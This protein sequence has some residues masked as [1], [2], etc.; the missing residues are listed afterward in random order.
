MKKK[1]LLILSSLILAGGQLYAAIST[2][3]K[4]NNK[5]KYKI[6][7]AIEW[8]TA[9]K[10]VDI[11]PNLSQ[12]LPSKKG[13]FRHI[14]WNVYDNKG[15]E[16]GSYRTLNPKTADENKLD[17]KDK[18][19]YEKNKLNFK[20]DI[21]ERYEYPHEITIKGNG[22]TYDIREESGLTTKS[23][24]TNVK[25]FNFIQEGQKT[26]AVKVEVKPEVKTT[27]TEKKQ[28][29][30][31]KK[32][33]ELNT[34]LLAQEKL[35]KEKIEKEQSEKTRKIEN[36]KN[37]KIK[38]EAEQ[39]K[40]SE[41]EKQKRENAE[42]KKLDEQKKSKAEKD[43]IEKDKKAKEQEKQKAIFKYKPEEKLLNMLFAEHK[44]AEEII[45]EIEDNKINLKNFIFKYDSLKT[46]LKDDGKPRFKDGEEYPILNLITQNSSSLDNTNKLANY[47]IEK[48]ADINIPT[49]SSGRTPLLY[50][51][52]RLNF[53][54][55]KKLIEKGANVNIV[56]K[57]DSMSVFAELAKLEN[58]LQALKKDDS[59]MDIDNKKISK[60]Q[61]LD[62]IFDMAQQLLNKHKAKNEKLSVLPTEYGRFTDYDYVHNNLIDEN[63]KK[64]SR[65]YML[66]KIDELQKE[67]KAVAD[68]QEYSIGKYGETWKEGEERIEKFKLERIGKLNAEIDLLKNKLDM[69]MRNKN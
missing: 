34:K 26:P 54:L 52:Q 40:R 32:E 67:I 30:A 59:T 20:N 29:A 53:E 22:E 28:D 19:R 63:Y 6:S 25:A 44:S 39:N 36:Q 4:L 27:A 65:L 41:Q 18:E 43:K 55:A 38:R 15:K 45:K 68:N 11:A 66:L 5:T 61:G 50:S 62:A 12:F 69:L 57:E 46:S 51:I 7:A 33:T 49:K 64:K 60:K 35:E 2:G 31:P 9:T 24:E 42:K 10:I 47:L 23:N 21:K 16:I 48:G 58:K 37:E 3:V 13:G 8:G 56:P 1:S 14:F 17:K